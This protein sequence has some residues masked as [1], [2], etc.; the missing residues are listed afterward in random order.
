M[1][2]KLHASFPDIYKDDNHK[3][4]VAIATEDNF[5]GLLGFLSNED[6]RYNISENR[7]LAEIFKYNEDVIIDS[8]FKKDCVYKMLFEFDKN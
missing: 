7:V 8:Q 6:L 3:P 1:A 5:T 2:E 4:E